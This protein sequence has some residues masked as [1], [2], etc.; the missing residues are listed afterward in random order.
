MFR[1]VSPRMEEALKT[2]YQASEAVFGWTKKK[3]GL[4]VRV[5]L[6]REG[7]TDTV[8]IDGWL[9]LAE[10][11]VEEETVSLVGKIKTKIPG[12]Y[13]SYGYLEHGVRYYSD[14]SG[15]PDSWEVE[16]CDPPVVGRLYAAIEHLFGMVLKQELNNLA[17]SEAYAN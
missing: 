2:C 16:D 14:G 3:D 17:E 6:E 5:D 1:P 15:Q 9:Y 12:W 13:L 7:D 4:R 8:V 11:E 10:T